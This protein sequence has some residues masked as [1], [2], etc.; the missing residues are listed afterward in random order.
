MDIF[1]QVKKILC[2]QLD[3]DEEQVTEDSEVIDDLGADSLDIVDLVMTLE[4]EF[5]TEIP[6]EDIENLRTVGDIVKYIEERSAE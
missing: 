3:L 1:E 6:D 2:D 4:E 5:D